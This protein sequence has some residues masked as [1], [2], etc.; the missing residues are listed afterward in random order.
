MKDASCDTA[1]NSLL[2]N[3]GFVIIIMYILFWVNEKDGQM[4]A[5]FVLVRL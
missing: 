3:H 5:D 2:M 4:P 1:E